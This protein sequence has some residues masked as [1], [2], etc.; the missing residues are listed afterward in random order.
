[1]TADTRFTN[2]TKLD[3][4]KAPMD[5]LP[6][7][8][9][10]G[11]AEVLDFGRVK[12][13]ENNWRKG[14]QWCRLMAACLR[15]C[16]AWLS[17]EDKDAESGLSHIDHA[18]CCLMFLSAHIKSKMG[19]DNRYKSAPEQADLPAARVPKNAPEM[20]WWLTEMNGDH[21]DGPFISRDVA[22]VARRYHVEQRNRL[23]LITSRFK[24]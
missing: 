20:Q 13:S 8:A 22:E 15:H 17:G 12:Y 18:T 7:E 4:K 6:W 11:V 16:F 10:Q 23:V 9:V 19:I 2:A 21:L 1:M 24:P 14:F 5:L 3:A